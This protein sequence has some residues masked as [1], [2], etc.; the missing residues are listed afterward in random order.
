MSQMAATMNGGRV[1]SAMWIAKEGCEDSALQLS[2]HSRSFG[3]GLKSP[4][5][6]V[7]LARRWVDA[8]EWPTQRPPTSYT[9]EP[10]VIAI[11]QTRHIDGVTNMATIN[12]RA[13][14]AILIAQRPSRSAVSLTCLS[15]D[16]HR[17][18]LLQGVQ[19]R[20]IGCR[21]ACPANLAA[22]RYS[23]HI[24]L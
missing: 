23:E 12:P 21:C 11:D 1:R 9:L 13:L 16:L 15:V 10:A 6:G 24:H 20:L 18:L 22:G 3:V 19:V 17:S 2:G 8:G 14:R 4:V 5:V 7:I